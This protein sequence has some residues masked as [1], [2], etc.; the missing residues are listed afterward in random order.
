MPLP[1]KELIARIR[2]SAQRHKGAVK[3]GMGDDCAVLRPAPGH[4]ILVT[5]DVTLE[6]T[7]FRRQWQAPEVVGRRCLTRGLSD[8]AAMG[9]EPAAAFLSLGL[10]GKISQKWV[11]RFMLGLLALAG[12]FKVPLAGGDVAQS[13]AGILA[14]IVVLGLIPKG[15]AI[16]RSGAKGGDRI[17]VTG[18]LGGSAAALELL[19][20]G[21][22]IRPQDFPHHFHPIPR[23]AVGRFLREKG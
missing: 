3:V 12:E 9:G 1:E 2:K 5:T 11:D 14:D 18:E 6:G 21:K 8:I 15:K 19:L 13:P 22:K 17:Y 7:H 20:A 16:M 10:P 4:E 23:I